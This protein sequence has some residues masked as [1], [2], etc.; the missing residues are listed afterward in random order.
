METPDA[1]PTPQGGAQTP[2]YFFARNLPAFGSIG[3]IGIMG[4][5]ISQCPDSSATAR[6]RCTPT[7]GTAYHFSLRS[8]FL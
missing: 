6:H 5:A 2:G 7:V 4:S 3:L 1:L 8:D